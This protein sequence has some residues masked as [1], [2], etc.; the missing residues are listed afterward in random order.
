MA[1]MS[2]SRSSTEVS[3]W[4]EYDLPTGVGNSIADLAVL[5]TRVPATAA[6]IDGTVVEMW[7][8]TGVA[9]AGLQKLRPCK[10]LN[11]CRYEGHQE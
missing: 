3:E 10:L 1:I 11:A 2:T 9:L 5:S 7:G 8:G 6:I 4:H